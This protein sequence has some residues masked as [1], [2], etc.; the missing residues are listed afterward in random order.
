MLYVRAI[1]P[2]AHVHRIARF[3]VLAEDAER[4]RAFPRLRQERKRPVQF[5]KQHVVS[6]RK[7]HEGSFVL[8]VRTVPTDIRKH[9]FARL[10]MRAQGPGQFQQGQ[11]QFRIYRFRGR[12]LGHRNALRLACYV[13]HP[14][15]L[16]IGT[17]G[18]LAKQHVQPAFRVRANRMLLAAVGG[19][20]Q[21]RLQRFRRKIAGRQFPRNGRPGRRAVHLA[22]HIRPVFSRTH[23][24]PGPFRGGNRGYFSGIDPVLPGLH[25]LHKPRVAEVK[26]L[27]PPGRGA[28][29]RSDI[30]QNLLHVRREAHID[31][32][33]ELIFEELDRSERRKRG[34]QLRSAA[35]HV[36]AAHDRVYNRGVGAGPS[37]ALFF[38]HLH[39]RGFRVPGGRLRL[40]L[41]GL[42]VAANQLV[43]LG[44]GRQRAV[45]MLQSGV[46]VV[47]PFHI[48]PVEPLKFN[49]LSRRPE[50]GRVLAFAGLDAHRAAAHAGLGHLARHGALPYQF[51]QIRLLATQAQFVSRFHIAPGGPNRLVRLLRVRHLAPETPWLRGQIFLA[52]PRGDRLPAGPNG[53]VG[54]LGGVGAHI[55]DQALL[56]E[57]LRDLHGPPGGKT[58]FAAPFLLQ[59]RSNERRRRRGRRHPLLDLDHP[60][61][62]VRQLGDQRPGLR[63]AKQHQVLARLQF[64]PEPPGMVVE[65]L[66]RGKAHPAVMRHF[67]LERLALRRQ[68][69]LQIEPDGRNEDHPLFLSL[70][71]QPGRHALYAPRGQFRGD[72]APKERGNAVSDEAVQNAPRFLRIYKASVDVSRFAERALDGFLRNFVKHH[73]PHRNPGRQRLDE[74]PAYRFALAVF[75]RG[76][77]Q[78]VDFLERRAK[79]SHH[80][81]LVGRRY[82][83]GGE[84]VVHVHAI[85]LP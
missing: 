15:Q 46:R 32:V 85:V 81:L 48:G 31:Q 26:V 44:H 5:H 8:H 23:D 77:V 1:P 14:A 84:P 50:A 72:L 29:S 74:M 18:A 22:F 19:S 38:E 34:R 62:A 82:V 83:H 39:Q 79:F 47:G 75:V 12:I 16:H 71:K 59:G 24:E 45:A 49:L 52:V 11:R 40:V 69:R 17:V 9:R 73:A 4:P 54:K 63:F 76:D 55:G 25:L 28:I 13:P 6:F 30:V 21:Q 43:A 67:R 65:I 80:F 3:R 41:H 64:F 33:G 2:L 10:G 37:D 27:Q 42:H 61:G 56:V 35:P 78:F 70:H 36:F 51:V 53:L 20:F 7:R 66:A 68:R 60:P 57:A 58:Q